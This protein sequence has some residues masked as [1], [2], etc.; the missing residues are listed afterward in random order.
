MALRIC[1]VN[2]A[3]LCDKVATKDLYIVPKGRALVNFQ[4]QEMEAKVAEDLARILVRFHA[5]GQPSTQVG[6]DIAA[7]QQ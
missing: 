3:G 1:G 5:A 6:R 7:L 2:H 4:C